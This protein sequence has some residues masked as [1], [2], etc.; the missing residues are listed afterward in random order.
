MVICLEGDMGMGKTLTTT[1][2][3]SVIYHGTLQQT[4][5]RLN[6]FSN[7]FLYH[8]PH[9]RITVEKWQKTLEQEEEAIERDEALA[10]IEGRPPTTLHKLPGIV[11][12]KGL[13]LLD[14]GYLYT[15]SRTSGSKMNRMFNYFF[16]QARKRKL[17]CFFP[18]HELSR[19]DRRIRKAVDINIQPYYNK[20][21]GTV[22]LS[23][24][25]VKSLRRWTK[26]Y[27]GNLGMDTTTQ[28][29]Q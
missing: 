19:L 11:Y 27:N 12:K 16:H 4:G 28:I 17:T 25:D 18:T 14:E 3:A 29:K 9:Q 26:H 20:V 1:Y 7:Y 22:R 8:L 21:T 6:I 2:L 13:F 24:Q 15:D 5:V 10:E 23:Y